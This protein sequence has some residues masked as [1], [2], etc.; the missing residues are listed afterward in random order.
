MHVDGMF[1][2]NN[3]SDAANIRQDPAKGG[4][5][6]PDIGVYTY[7]A[8][9]FVTGQ[10]P[11]AITHADLTFENGVDVVARVAAQFSGFSAHW[12]NSMRMH[13]YQH[14]AFH[15]DKGVLRLTAP[16]NPNVYDVAQIELHQPDLGLRVERFPAVNHYVL[17]VEAFCRS[18]RLSEPFA[19]T[20]ED[21]R[22]TQVMID[23]VYAKAAE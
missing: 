14:M 5:G 16:F 9:R 10:E 4:G 21:A 7:G 15:G 1:T 6:I 23:R 13:S 3:A 18:V 8:T 2:Y 17:Q 19:W 12:V 11:T 22:G 20:L